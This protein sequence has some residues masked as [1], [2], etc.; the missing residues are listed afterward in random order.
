MLMRWACCVVV[1]FKPAKRRCGAITMTPPSPFYRIIR[2]PGWGNITI[3]VMLV[4]SHPIPS[5]NIIR[6][7]C[8]WGGWLVSPKL[9]YRSMVIHMNRC[10]SWFN[11]ACP[12]IFF[13]KSNC[14]TITAS[15]GE[16]FNIIN[17]PFD[18]L[19][20][21]VLHRSRSTYACCICIFIW[22]SFSCAN[23]TAVWVS[24]NG[25]YA[26]YMNIPFV[27]LCIRVGFNRL[28]VSIFIII[29]ISDCGSRV[30]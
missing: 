8:Q 17:E 30:Y 7:P 18:M 23:D 19:S 13:Y 3:R 2:C 21:S 29:S 25:F 22:D 26:G 15:T 16:I 24:F 14:P 5:N 11:T 27:S 4:M 28:N 6:F 20:K 9:T 1:N 12:I 10:I